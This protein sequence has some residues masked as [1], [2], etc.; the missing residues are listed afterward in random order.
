VP[1]KTV[2]LLFFSFC[3]ILASLDQ[4]LNNSDTIGTNCQLQL[5]GKFV[6]FKKQ[7]KT[8]VKD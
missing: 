2:L 1:E 8:F 6:Q 5:S 4:F 7:L 3:D